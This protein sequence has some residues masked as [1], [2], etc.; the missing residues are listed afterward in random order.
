MS[1]CPNSTIRFTD[2][3]KWL[4]LGVFLV[5]SLPLF[6]ELNPIWLALYNQESL[7]PNQDNDGD[8]ATNQMEAVAGTHPL[9][10]SDHF[11]ASALGIQQNGILVRWNSV[12]GRRYA[13][14]HRATPNAAWYT[15][16][17]E[18]EGLDGQQEAIL[19]E[20]NPGQGQVRLRIVTASP[21]LEAA[22][23]AMNASDTDADGQMDIDLQYFRG[24]CRAFHQH[25][26]V[27]ALRESLSGAM[28][29]GFNR[30]QLG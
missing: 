13:I 26:M 8:G 1:R 2:A 7:D 24:N 27:G 17:T 29:A 19:E 15:V 25:R 4:F 5:F 23:M 6:A 11:V 28:L 12:K 20:L 14:D 9:D 10:P 30:W 21:A 16:H 3:R 18:I 22:K